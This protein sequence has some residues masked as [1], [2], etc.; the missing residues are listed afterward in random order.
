MALFYAL[1][2]S[3]TRIEADSFILSPLAMLCGES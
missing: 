1:N 3:A 2:I